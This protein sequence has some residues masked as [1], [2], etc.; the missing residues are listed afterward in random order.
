MLQLRKA[1]EIGGRDVFCDA[2]EAGR[3][4]AI[5]SHPLYLVTGVINLVCKSQR[6][7][8]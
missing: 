5:L 1:S 7:T 3:K 2:G 8:P 4:R 6:M